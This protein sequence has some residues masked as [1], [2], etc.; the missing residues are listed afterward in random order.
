MRKAS[1]VQ[2]ST[3]LWNASKLIKAG[4]G[5]KL[6]EEAPQRSKKRTVSKE[7]KCYTDADLD[8]LRAFAQTYSTQHQS[9]AINSA[10]KQSQDGVLATTLEH[11]V[12][13]WATWAGMADTF[14]GPKN[15]NGMTGA[16]MEDWWKKQEEGGLVPRPRCDLERATMVRV[17]YHIAWA[18]GD[19]DEL[20]F[21]RIY[22]ALKARRKHSENE[23]TEDGRV[24]LSNPKPLEARQLDLHRK[25]SRGF[26]AHSLDCCFPA[27]LCL[28]MN[29]RL[30]DFGNALTRQW[31]TRSELTLAIQEQQSNALRGSEFINVENAEDGFF[32]TCDPEDQSKAPLISP[33]ELSR[34]ITKA[35]CQRFMAEQPIARKTR[36]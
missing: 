19:C 4:T 28:V 2:K 36:K 29:R 24:I 14:S 23:K 8:D 25:R 21:K 26:P 3:S 27:A 15:R 7:P 20:F 18:V 1:G 11:E 10:R 31:I 33:S 13:M 16:E 30:H 17:A 22:T 32:S 12:M 34:Q 6:R 5:K 9:A 35:G